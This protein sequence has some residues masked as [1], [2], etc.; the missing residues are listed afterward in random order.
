MT[1]RQDRRN[2]L[3]VILIA[4]MFLLTAA[5]VAVFAMVSN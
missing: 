1:K 2:K 3:I 4:I 5:T